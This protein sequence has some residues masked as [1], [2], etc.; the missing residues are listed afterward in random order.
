MTKREHQKAL[1]AYAMS[2][3]PG[4]EFLH[5]VSKP[6]AQQANH[7]ILLTL[8]ISHVEKTTSDNG[9]WEYERLYI[10]GD[11]KETTYIELEYFVAKDCPRLFLHANLYT[12]KINLECGSSAMEGYGYCHTKSNALCD[13]YS[14]VFR[15][16]MDHPPTEDGLLIR[17][18]DIV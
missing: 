8:G 2:L 16:L 9:Y 15:F 13:G 1:N 5:K 3:Y 12:N 18:C 7:F 14:G 4:T 10:T 17:R 6:S 11:G